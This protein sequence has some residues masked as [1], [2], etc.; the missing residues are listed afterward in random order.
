MN[1]DE[2]VNR[3]RD[4]EGEQAAELDSTRIARVVITMVDM[5]GSMLWILE[6]LAL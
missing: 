6:L 2:E 1:M 5:Y 3:K 4:Y